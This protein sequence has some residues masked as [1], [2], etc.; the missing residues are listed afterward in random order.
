MT[1]LLLI[2]FVMLTLGLTYIV[3]QSSIFILLRLW[4]NAKAQLLGTLIYCP[5]CSGFWIG[6]VLGLLGAWPLPTIL[7]PLDAAIAAC[8]LMA[9]WAMTCITTTSWE[10]EQHATQEET[11]HE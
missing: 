2:R 9:T 3:T 4:L 6:M 10:L 11:P 5:A 7:G 1:I 8:G